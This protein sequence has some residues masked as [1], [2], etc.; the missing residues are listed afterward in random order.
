MDVV[1]ISDIHG[2]LIDVPECDLLLIAGD[3]CPTEDHSLGY[4]SD[5]L[6]RAFRYWL[7]DVPAKHIVGI[8]GNHDFIFQ[9]AKGLVPELPWS[10][11]QDSFTIIDGIKIHGTPWQPPYFDWAFNLPEERM[12]L[13]FDLIDPDTDIVISHGP[14]YGQGDRT[15]RGEYAGSKALLRALKRVQPQYAVVG[16]IHQGYGHYRV[17]KTHV[18]NAAVVDGGYRL[19]NAPIS[20]SI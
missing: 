2:H 1:A 16:H 17:G 11:L 13:V 6:N 12:E 5:W 10:Y 14:P 18:K 4:Q 20:F 15:D 9:D 3:I 8:A 19:R 7:E